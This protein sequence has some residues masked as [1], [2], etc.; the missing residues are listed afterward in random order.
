MRQTL[1]FILNGQAI[2]PGQ[3]GRV[4]L[5]ITRLYNNTPLDLEVIIEHG[6]YTGPTLLV[7]A[8]IHGDELNGVE[9]CRR[10]LQ[11]QLAAKLHGTLLIVPVVNQLGFI[12][13]SRYL[14][15]RRDL[16]RCFPGSARG[17]LGSRMAAQ[18]RERLLSQAD[19]AIDLH[20]GAIHRSN[21]PQIRVDIDDPEGMRL[22]QLFN[23][24][25]ILNAP[26]REGSFRA[27]SVHS[28][29]PMIVYEAGEALRFDPKSIRTGE[30]GIRQ[31]MVGLNMLPK[32]SHRSPKVKPV[33][34]TRS[35]WLRSESDGL[36]LNHAALGQYLSQGETVATIASPFV[37]GQV[38]QLKAKFDGIVI[39][40]NHLPVV[41]EG[42]AILHIAELNG[43]PETQSRAA[44][45]QADF[46]D[47][48]E[49]FPPIGDNSIT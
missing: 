28:D 18:I 48:N 37:Q 12:Q 1:P 21:L 35:S 32:R 46:D 30:R 26:L 41:N 49:Y 27:S 10:L 17:A 16:N 13:Q 19:Y 43:D 45:I 6:R 9:I 36:L 38:Q 23:P 44:S 39:G 11:R 14:P 4:F 34:A 3:Q 33:I 22:A 40:L 2:S 24:P 5:P 8:A 47:P 29:T 42:D 20:T 31:V 15:D 25:L 7:T